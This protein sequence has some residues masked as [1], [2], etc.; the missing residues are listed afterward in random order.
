[1][2]L[3]ELTGREDMA[4]GM[5]EEVPQLSYILIPMFYFLEVENNTICCSVRLPTETIGTRYGQES[6]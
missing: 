4:T 5:T 1:M 6:N 3:I 2:Q